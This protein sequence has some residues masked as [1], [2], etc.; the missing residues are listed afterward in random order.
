MIDKN[1]GFR[2]RARAKLN[3]H[4]SKASKD[5]QFFDETDSLVDKEKESVSIFNENR[6][7]VV[8]TQASREYNDVDSEFNDSDQRKKY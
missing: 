2:P 6:K 8:E 7:R 5:G 4:V 3:N 1:G